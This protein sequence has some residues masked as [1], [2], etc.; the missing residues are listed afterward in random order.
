MDFLETGIVLSNIGLTV[1]IW[2]KE[3]GTQSDLVD[4]KKRLE[5]QQDD[6]G[7]LSKNISNIQR[8]GCRVNNER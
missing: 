3:V 4:I 6:I 7:E 2:W 8:Y 1:A 5:Q